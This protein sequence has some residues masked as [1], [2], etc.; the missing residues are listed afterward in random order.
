MLH[1]RLFK[2]LLTCFARQ[3]SQLQTCRK[4][5]T[6]QYGQYERQPSWARHCRPLG[7]NT[8][9]PI[10]PLTAEHNSSKNLH[11]TFAGLSAL[12][13]HD[14][15]TSVAKPHRTISNFNINAGFSWLCMFCTSKTKSDVN[16]KGQR[17]QCVLQENIDR[18][19]T[20][21]VRVD[22]KDNS[23]KFDTR[24]CTTAI[25]RHAR[26]HAV[27]KNEWGL[28]RKWHKCNKTYIL[29]NGNKTINYKKQTKKP[30]K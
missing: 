16:L 19:K 7:R 17:I 25:P 4:F 30:N 14:S 1:A 11:W 22:S 2:G 21:Q 29:K 6:S 18:A 3:V 23:A 5:F 28:E 10:K 24:M 9:S 26:W 12:D 8:T 27:S 20:R 15:P 13:P